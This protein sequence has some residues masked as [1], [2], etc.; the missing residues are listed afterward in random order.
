MYKWSVAWIIKRYSVE[1]NVIRRRFGSAAAGVSERVPALYTARTDTQVRA[2]MHIFI[3][4]CEQNIL[5]S[6]LRVPRGVSYN[7]ITR[8]VCVKTQ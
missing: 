1:F 4:V 7:I 6:L 5:E 8:S 3:C 2:R